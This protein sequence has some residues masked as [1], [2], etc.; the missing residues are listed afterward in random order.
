MYAQ[1]GLKIVH[2]KDL[3]NFLFVGLLSGLGWMSWCFSVRKHRPYYT[4]MLKFYM[5]V[6]FSMILEISDFP[7]VF[8]IFDAHSLWHLSTV[9][10]TF[11]LYK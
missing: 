8:W 9:P 7:P 11:V 6:A 5:L 4:L 3:I 1:V 10:I 2:Y